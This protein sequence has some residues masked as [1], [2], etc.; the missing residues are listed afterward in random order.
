MT[1]D[2]RKR[3][4]EEGKARA[5][6]KPWTEPSAEGQA[7]PSMRRTNE[8]GELI[9][10]TTENAQLATP[11]ATQRPAASTCTN[12]EAWNAWL[13]QAIDVRLA[14]ERA[15]M[16]EILG[17]IVA[18]MRSEYQRDADRDAQINE[19]FVKI[20]KSLEQ[21]TKSIVDL[22]RERVER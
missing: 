21:A 12:D 13:H 7:S 17:E 1:D 8:P 5:V 9:Y 11:E 18:K 10:K 16:I 22:R 15:E 6:G 3:I 4:I 2:D 20:W 14:E 19:E